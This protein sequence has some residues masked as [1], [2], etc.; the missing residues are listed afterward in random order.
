[1]R[2]ARGRRAPWRR[3]V[4]F[5]W[6]LALVALAWLL[7]P[8]RA[9]AEYPGLPCTAGKATFL[10]HVSYTGLFIPAALVLVLITAGVRRAL[11]GGRRGWAVLLG[12]LGA[13]IAG[14]Y[15][16]FAG[17]YAQPIAERTVTCPP[18]AESFQPLRCWATK[19]LDTFQ[20][21]GHAV[22]PRDLAEVEALG[23]ALAAQKRDVFLY[24]AFL[25]D[26]TDPAVADYSNGRLFVLQRPELSV[27]G[28][29]CLPERLAKAQE[30]QQHR[31]GFY[32][33]SARQSPAVDAFFLQHNTP[34]G[35]QY[36]VID[37][38]HG[39]LQ[40]PYVRPDDLRPAESAYL[41]RVAA[42]L[43]TLNDDLDRELRSAAPPAALVQM[44]QDFERIAREL[45]D[46]TP[47][48]LI[49]YRDSRL[50]RFLENYDLILVAEESAAQGQ[51]PRQIHASSYEQ[52]RR[53]Y[54]QEP[55]VTR[56]IG[57]LYL[58]EPGESFSDDELSTVNWAV[59]DVR[60]AGR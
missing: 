2:A 59:F 45:A 37:F 39:D 40:L 49:R 57:Y 18:A 36:E 13:G 17:L 28:S 56:L 19:D 7:A 15:L 14:A 1:M 12:A 44:R 32:R 24:E 55:H 33:F 31:V 30:V 10:E 23:R 5:A 46:G 51:N 3:R 47:D 43:A 20:M 9:R 4:V 53:F 38:R 35:P 22:S 50:K 52:H 58:Q 16:A 11:S 41:D 54:F 21:N 48:R 27:F 25:L 60:S 29:Q 26:T 34:E 8:L 6:P 42:G